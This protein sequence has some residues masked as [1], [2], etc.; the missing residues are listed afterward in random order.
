MDEKRRAIKIKLVEACDRGLTWILFILFLE[1][2][3]TLGWLGVAGQTAVFVCQLFP[4]S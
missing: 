1:V 4:L 2:D 3:K